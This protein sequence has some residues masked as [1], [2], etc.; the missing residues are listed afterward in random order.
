MLRIGEA[1]DTAVSP[2]GTDLSIE[3]AGAGAGA[4][5]QGRGLKQLNFL[6]E[7]N[8]STNSHI[9]VTD[10]TLEAMVTSMITQSLGH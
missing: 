8:I 1:H 3:A 2:S 7:H 10:K 9:S 4:G 5:A 6:Y